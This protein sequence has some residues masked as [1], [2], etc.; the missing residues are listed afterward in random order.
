MPP[1]PQPRKRKPPQQFHP[2]HRIEATYRR[3]LDKFLLKHLHFSVSDTLDSIL[4]RLSD[5]AQNTDFL[6]HWSATLAARMITNTRNSNAKSW[7]EAAQQSGRGREIYQALQ[8]ELYGPV[9]ERITEL[10]NENARLIS[11]IP[12][13]VSE[14]V[15]REIAAMQQKGLRPETI[16]Q[17]LQRRI[18]QLTKSRVALIAR[19]ES[20][21][22]ATA[23]T[24]ARS[25]SMGVNCYQWSTSYDQRVRVS[26]RKMEGVIVFWNDPPSP[27]ALLGIKSTLGNYHA[28]NC[29][30]CRCVPLPVV[31]ISMIQFPAKVFYHN[32]IER[33]TLAR[34]SAVSGITKAA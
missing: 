21:K 25:E 33:M 10:V 29:P 1:K 6:S 7:R 34:F 23:L 20:S 14:S 12:S 31:A 17:H 24:H 22:A 9:G 15:A 19:T 13:R 5:L 18:P 16:A 28:G 3:E 32:K 8:E 27:E 30:N 4:Q 11:S 26:H 2:P